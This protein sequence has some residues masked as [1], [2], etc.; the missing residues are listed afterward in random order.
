[1][2]KALLVQPEA[3]RLPTGAEEAGSDGTG[4]SEFA[5]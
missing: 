4:V 2:C 5:P 3:P 1:M